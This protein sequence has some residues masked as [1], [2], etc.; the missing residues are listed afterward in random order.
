MLNTWLCD[1]RSRP[2]KQVLPFW[3]NPMDISY[4]QFELDLKT[5]VYSQEPSPLAIVEESET[6]TAERNTIQPFAFI[7]PLVQPASNGSTALR[8]IFQ[9][10]KIFRLR[11]FISIIVAAPTR[12]ALHYPFFRQ[13]QEP[14]HHILIPHQ[15]ETTRSGLYLSLHFRHFGI[16]PNTESTSSVLD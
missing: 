7:S 11:S 5:L 12:R 9:S 3:V 15:Y 8:S 14:I 16:H 2:S 1:A 13:S 4:Y 6:R 10:R